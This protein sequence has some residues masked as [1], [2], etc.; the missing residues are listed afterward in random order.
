[1]SLSIDLYNERVDI[2]HRSVPSLRDIG[3]EYV[4]FAKEIVSL[5]SQATGS[6]VT[7]L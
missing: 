7:D 2:Y 4:R 1:M 6:E 5:M 3:L